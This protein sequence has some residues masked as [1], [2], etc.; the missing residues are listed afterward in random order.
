LGS[1]A[2]W[3]GRDTVDAVYAKYERSEPAADKMNWTY[4]FCTDFNE[5]SSITV[6]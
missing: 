4:L 3:Y 1:F 2:N 6:K 5:S